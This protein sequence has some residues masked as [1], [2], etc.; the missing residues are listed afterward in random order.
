MRRLISIS[1]LLLAPI[2]APAQDVQPSKILLTN[3]SLW[4]GT[5][6]TRSP[7]MNL[8]IDG[9]D[10]LRRYRLSPLRPIAAARRKSSMAAAAR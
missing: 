6:E 8:L 2:L 10:Q 7:G 5:S 4:D 1:I 3:V 9:N